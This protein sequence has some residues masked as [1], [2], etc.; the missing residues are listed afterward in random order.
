MIKIYSD[1]AYNPNT[2]EAGIG[3]QIIVGNQRVLNKLHIQSVFDNHL[4]EFIGLISALN[5]I[6]AEYPLEQAILF[7]SDSK[8]LIQSIDKKYSNHSEYQPALAYI[9][10]KIKLMELFFPKWIP[11]VE[12]KG[13]DHLAKQALRLEGKVFKKIDKIVTDYSIL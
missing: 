2:K 13:A 3:I 8:I 7:Y 1:A 11:E 6:E 9:L 10:D 4:A 5:Y 12:N